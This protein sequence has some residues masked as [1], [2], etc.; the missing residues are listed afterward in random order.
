MLVL[1]VPSLTA[2]SAIESDQA[3]PAAPSPLTMVVTIGAGCFPRSLATTHIQ[4]KRG[5]AKVDELL[6]HDLST[7]LDLLLNLL[8]DLMG[9]DSRSVELQQGIGPA[10]LWFSKIN[11]QRDSS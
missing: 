6:R 2:S 1:P 9:H 5:A 10:P 7:R 4:F 3:V 11:A 8:L